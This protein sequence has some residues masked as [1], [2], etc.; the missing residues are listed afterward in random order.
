MIYFIQSC[1][2]YVKIGTSFSLEERVKGLQTASPKKLKVKA[3]LDGGFQTESE[4]HKLFERAHV[5][6]EWFKTTEE[7]KWYIRAIQENPNVTNIYSL[8][9][10]S[11]QMRL[12][13]KAKRL[14]KEHKLSQRIG[15]YDVQLKDKVQ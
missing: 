4:L 15:R 2:R 8:Y 5:R 9:K 11:Q 14:G 3:V 1:N 6:G 10:I 7:V 13:A 12:R